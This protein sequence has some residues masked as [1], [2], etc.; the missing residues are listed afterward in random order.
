MAMRRGWGAGLL[1][2][3]IGL[4]LLAYTAP[5]VAETSR[6]YYLMIGSY[7][8]KSSLQGEIR[9]LKRWG[10]PYQARQVTFQGRIWYRL[11]TGPFP[12][13][14]R[15]AARQKALHVKTGRLYS[16]FRADMMGKLVSRWDGPEKVVSK[17]PSPSVAPLAKPKPVLPLVMAK[18]VVPPP[19][20]PPAVSPP[21]LPI[22]A[23]SVSSNL[24]PTMPTT[25]PKPVVEQPEAVIDQSEPGLD[26]DLVT[27][28]DA[29]AS[30]EPSS[31][32]VA[33]MRQI[34]GK[35]PPPLMIPPTRDVRPLT[36][37]VQ[38]KTTER[39]PQTS[40][41]ITNPPV[42]QS[43]AKPTVIKPAAIKPVVAK[44]AAHITSKESAESAPIVRPAPMAK[45]MAKITP[46]VPRKPMHPE[47]AL[48]GTPK[49]MTNGAV[50]FQ[51]RYEYHPQVRKAKPIIWERQPGRVLPPGR[52]SVIQVPRLGRLELGRS[53]TDLYQ[54]DMIQADH[55]SALAFGP[56]EYR[57]GMISAGNHVSVTLPP[58]EGSFELLALRMQAIALLELRSDHYQVDHLSVGAAAQ[59]RMAPG[60]YA[61]PDLRVGNFSAVEVSGPGKVVLTVQ[62]LLNFNASVTLN[63]QGKSEQFLV[64][65]GEKG[66]ASVGDKARIQASLELGVGAQ[67]A[68]GTKAWFGAIKNRGTLYGPGYGAALKGQEY[69]KFVQRMGLVRGRRLLE[70][71]KLELVFLKLPQVLEELGLK[72]A[73][74]ADALAAF[75]K[76]EGIA[77]SRRLDPR[78]LDAVARKARKIRAE[79]VRKSREEGASSP[80]KSP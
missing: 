15:T 25:P 70:E 47:A 52:Y 80:V 68:I 20:V 67:M 64:R 24:A 62:D 78:T 7:A 37:K 5:A 54:I 31:P 14:K 11:L 74:D 79:E 73:D 53:E 63:S 46:D 35:L 44:P 38:P 30:A 23:K 19:P 26:M 10:I 16:F 2:V 39:S 72:G 76:L 9:R 32:L 27:D 50:I 49:G 18:P 55:K 43:V 21:V 40:K 48:D 42:V 17:V 71:K 3:W 57:I 75:Q 56:G 51:E 8:K 29:V 1:M 34:L 60:Q 41:R 58:S 6:T 77:T 13:Q 36:K 66:I 28:D 65:L 59:I 33:P 12:D 45:I 4:L 69:K 61:F 22:E